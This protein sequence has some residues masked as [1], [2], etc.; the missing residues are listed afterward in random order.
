MRPETPQTPPERALGVKGSARAGLRGLFRPGFSGKGRSLGQAVRGWGDPVQGGLALW[1]ALV[2][3]LAFP[4]A[5]VWPLV[6]IAPA[7]LWTLCVG[8]S[9]GRAFS[10]GWA[11]GVGFFGALLWWIV[12]TV[13]RY[14]GL[15]WA[16][17]VATVVLLAAYLALYPAACAAAVAAASLRSPAAAL[18]L[19][20]FLWVGLE[21]LRGALLTGF[22]WG[23]L[24]QAL[25]RCQW[26]L[27]LAPWVG[28]E[29]V[30]FLIGTL[31]TAVA[32]G[33]LRWG[34]HIPV[35]PAPLVLAAGACAVAAWLWSLPAPLAH[36]QG[37]LRAAV[38]QGN[39]EQAQKWDPAFRRATLGIYADLS[40]VAAQSGPELYLWP[41]TAVPLYAQDPGP[42]RGGLEALARELDAY[43]VFGAPAY[44][45]RGAEVEYRNGVFLMGPDG[46]IAGRYDKVHLVPF[47]EYVP[48]GRYLPFLDKLVAGAGDFTSG[49]SVAPLPRQPGLPTLGALVCFEVIFP[50]LASELAARGA[51]V[52]VVVTNDG[53]FG[54][55]PGPH[56]HLAFAAWRAAEVGVPLLRAANTG[57][58]AVFDPTGRLLRAT[59]LQVPDVLSVE[60]PYSGPH[61]TPQ[62]R[63]RPWIW[64]TCLVL[65]LV[66]LSVTLLCLRSPGGP[67][68]HR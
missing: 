67:D 41:E 16:A 68:P 21:G 18:V 40:R 35:H 28:I 30:R 20:P 4:P 22:P 2:A 56:Q 24:P 14:G 54:R 65:A 47:G 13:V 57:V 42:E 44:E 32:W 8:V 6:L 38:I 63:I 43:L 11:Y 55:T 15:P 5:P 9:P 53:W 66:G 48:F 36:E 45:R 59:P 12:L 52:L 31:G 58:S 60:I 29:G 49:P 64:P 51:Q 39:V 33:L 23:D 19:A 1:G 61:R 7:P 37:R 3:A 46:G 25:W 62:H 27:A 10:R 26:A 17:G 50:S 34:R